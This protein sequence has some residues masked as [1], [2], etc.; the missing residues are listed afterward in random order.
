M[1]ETGA[2]SQARMQPRVPAPGDW[3]P[4]AATRNQGGA[5]SRNGHL[6]LAAAWGQDLRTALTQRA[7]SGL[8]GQSEEIVGWEGAEA[9][10]W[11][12]FSM[13]ILG[14]SGGGRRRGKG[15]EWVRGEGD[16]L[17]T[18]AGRRATRCERR[19]PPRSR[20]GANQTHQGTSDSVGCTLLSKCP[21]D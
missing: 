21:L 7:G 19:G 6:L 15:A 9:G 16:F 4:R 2:A 11:A 3:T 14:Q 17:G 5:W 10:V 1:G 8:V 13:D 18:R 20:Q 12:D